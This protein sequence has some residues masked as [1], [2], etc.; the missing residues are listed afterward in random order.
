MLVLALM[1]ACSLSDGLPYDKNKVGRR[2]FL[3]WPQDHFRV[4]EGPVPGLH[5]KMNLRHVF[6]AVEGRGCD[7]RIL[8]GAC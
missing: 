6:G 5:V 4:F 3:L 2:I 1:C 8:A 7:G